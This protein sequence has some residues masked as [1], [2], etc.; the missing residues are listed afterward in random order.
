MEV[1]KICIFASVNEKT[2]GK[3]QRAGSISGR[4]WLEEFDQMR[5]VGLDIRSSRVLGRLSTAGQSPI[6]LMFAQ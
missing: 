6:L 4:F 2:K 5:K 1:V 3:K